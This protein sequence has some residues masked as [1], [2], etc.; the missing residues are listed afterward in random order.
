MKSLLIP[1]GLVYAK[2]IRNHRLI[3]DIL[4]HNEIVNEGKNLILNIM[5]HGIAAVH[6][7]YVGLIDTDSYTGISLSDTMS[8]HVGWI[9]SDDYDEGTRAEYEED[10]ASNQTIW[11]PISAF[12]IFTINATKT[13]KGIFVTSDDAKNGS[14]GYLWSTALFEDSN[15]GEDWEVEDDDVVQIQYGVHIP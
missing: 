12:A 11:N 13:L 4:F 15:I 9:E 2:L 10:A 14:S 7:W 5:F 8:S 6:P 1:R 3:K